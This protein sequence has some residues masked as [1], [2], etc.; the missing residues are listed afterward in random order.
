MLKLPDAGRK[1]VANGVGQ[2]ECANSVELGVIGTD[3]VGGCANALH[4][5]QLAVGLNRSLQGLPT[6]ING[7][8]L[9]LV[10]QQP[11]MKAPGQAIYKE[12][13]AAGLGC[14]LRLEE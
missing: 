8:P 3:L 1:M 14:L 4:P 11:M 10:M 13:G 9:P 5:T 2:Q 6:P 7:S 12:T